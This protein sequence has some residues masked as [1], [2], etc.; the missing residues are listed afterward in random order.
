MVRRQG[1]QVGQRID[2][3]PNLFGSM[4]IHA[5]Q[6]LHHGEIIRDSRVVYVQSRDELKIDVK[7]G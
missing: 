5:Y 2:L 7:P 4:E 1:R 6:M 3:P